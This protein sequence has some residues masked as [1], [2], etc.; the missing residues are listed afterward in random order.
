MVVILTTWFLLIIRNTYSVLEVKHN[1]I[2]QID[3]YFKC[4]LNVI[5]NG[6]LLDN[7][8]RDKLKEVASDVI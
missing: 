5:Q 3:F 8:H 6:M 1:P 2:G 4:H 7:P